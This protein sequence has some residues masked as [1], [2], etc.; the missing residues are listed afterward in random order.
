MSKNRDDSMSSLACDKPVEP[1]DKPVEPVEP[2]AE[3]AENDERSE[4]IH[5][6][7]ASECAADKESSKRHERYREFFEKSGDFNESENGELMS[8][9]RLRIDSQIYNKFHQNTNFSS[10]SKRLWMVYKQNANNSKKKYKRGLANTIIGC[11]D[12]LRRSQSPRMISQILRAHDG[13]IWSTTEVGLEEI[14]SSDSE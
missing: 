14:K 1:V 11:V 7:V 9:L 6:S 3:N 8:A 10:Q 5:T 13:A 4:N 2:V 12:I